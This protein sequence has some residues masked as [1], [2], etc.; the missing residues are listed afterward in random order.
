[1]DPNQTA[2]TQPILI[3]K[4]NFRKYDVY[5]L[6]IQISRADDTAGNFSLKISL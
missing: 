3:E 6:N 2:P 1:M 5:C 4:N